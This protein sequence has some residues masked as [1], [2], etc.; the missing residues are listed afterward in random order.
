MNAPDDQNKILALFKHGPNI[1]E[2]SLAG[3]TDNELDYIPSSGGWTIRQIV[4]HITDGDDI[5]EMAIKMALGG[6]ESE[7]NLNWY[8]VM[9]QMEWAKRWS[10]EKR[11]IDISLTLFRA[12]R[13]HI[14]QLLENTPDA[15]TKNIK[16]P[17]PDGKIEIIPV[18]FILQ[19]Q[20][21]HLV[22]HV[23]R[24][25]EIRKEILG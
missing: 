4:H 20:A 19:M 12:T 15:W 21:D 5:W 6:E 7:F 18:G 22:H 3:L 8:K 16:S 24:I 2:K 23:N 10:Y 25:A 13:N 9:P 11:S 14:M 17:E 1:L